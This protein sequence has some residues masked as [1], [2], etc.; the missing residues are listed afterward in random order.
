MDKA[1]TQAER[2]KGPLYSFMWVQSS[3]LQ[4][5]QKCQEVW[6]PLVIELL[7]RWRWAPGPLFV[8]I[9]LN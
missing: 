9:C 7:W 8:H 4:S 1:L 5:L 6:Q 2:S 3:D